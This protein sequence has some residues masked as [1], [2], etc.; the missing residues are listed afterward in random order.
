M[1]GFSGKIQFNNQVIKENE[2]SRLTSSLTDANAPLPEVHHWP[3]G[4]FCN[5]IFLPV[6]Q[7]NQLNRLQTHSSN[8]IITGNIRL[9]NREEIIKEL[10]LS[11]EHYHDNI[12]SYLVLKGY[13]KWG[14]DCLK[15]FIGDFAFGIWD[16]QKNHL[17]A[18]RDHIGIKQL[19]Y[20]HNSKSILFG[21]RITEI[22]K[23]EDIQRKIN[24]DYITDYLLDIYPHPSKTIFQQIMQLPHGCYF[25][26]T[27]KN[28]TIKRYWSPSIKKRP[29]FQHNTQETAP[30]YDHLKNALE[31]RIDHSL[32]NGLMISGGLDSSSLLCIAKKSLKGTINK[33]KLFSKIP[34]ANNPDLYDGEEEFL[35][36]TLKHT[37]LKATY[38]SDEKSP[39][40]DMLTKYYR[41]NYSLPYN[42]FLQISS[43]LLEM[44]EKANVHNVITGF[45]GDETVSSFAPNI[46]AL[47]T[48]TGRWITLFSML[49]KARK[50]GSSVLSLIKNK[51][52]FP[53]L[54]QF[55]QTSYRNYK[56]P[57][58]FNILK[59]HFLIKQLFKEKKLQHHFQK[60]PGWWRQTNHLDPRKDILT[61]L[62]NSY[63]QETL[64]FFN[65]LGRMYSHNTAYPLL[66]LR[67]I[68]TCLSAPP[69]AFAK[70]GV[71]RSL[72]RNAVKGVIPEEIEERRTKSTF[73][74][75]ADKLLTANPEFVKNILDQENNP[76]WLIMD[77]KKLSDTYD[78]LLKEHATLQN[79][80]AIAYQIGRYLNVAAFLQWLD[81]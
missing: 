76:A 51:I 8:L 24:I 52:I 2:L 53:L 34:P 62:S 55:L 14:T 33:I 42:P 78:K 46:Y 73:A 47:L 21:G 56:Q 26:A 68:E 31:R 9:Y 63:L 79:R 43:P 50:T 15:Y 30:L 69:T 71:P 4:C 6:K 11:D 80:E 81:K 16:F 20:S 35:N 36:I 77:R 17:F 66:D 13:E 7:K 39:T 54:P 60:Q 40:L 5:K 32:Q 38:C 10:V 18:A 23:S 1:Y 65:A 57:D 44:V 27:D 67:V 28:V 64:T 49:R 70:D 59:E 3:G 75:S 37:N 22:I 61:T 45:G 25:I 19:F 48:I 74:K 72:L 58:K 12:D 29:F 41:E